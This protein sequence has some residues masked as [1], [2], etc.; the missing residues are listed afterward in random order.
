MINNI[1]TSQIGF[2]LIVLISSILPF[3]TQLIIVRALGRFKEKALR[4]KGAI[5]SILIGFIPT[6]GLFFL[7]AVLSGNSS[8]PG[9]FWS[10]IFLFSVYTLIA[11]VYFHIF[12]MS[13]TARRI[14]ILAESHRAGKIIK[15]EIV[16]NYTA[17]Q[18][19]AIRVDR[20]VALGEIKLRDERYSIARGWLL[21]PA[22]LVFGFR[23]FLFPSK[24]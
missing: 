8:V 14:R 3:L 22:S 9:L 10:G 12:N 23:R 7:W 13:E 21:F 11:Y 1:S 24:Q 2:I 18:M 16:Q 6:G 15:S 20:L 17:E 5:I 4:Q 19:I